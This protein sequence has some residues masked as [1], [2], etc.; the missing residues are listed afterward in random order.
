MPSVHNSVTGDI[1]LHATTLVCLFETVFFLGGAP[2]K[3]CL[4]KVSELG[5]RHT[6]SRAPS[7]ASRLR[8]LRES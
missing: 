7:G 2:E 6:H 3:I 8:P 1:L 4:I 5:H